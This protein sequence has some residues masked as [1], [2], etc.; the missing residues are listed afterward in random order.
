MTFPALLPHTTLR[1]AF[2]VLVP[3]FQTNHFLDMKWNPLNPGL[4]LTLRKLFPGV[5]P[6]CF[7]CLLSAG[8][9]FIIVCLFNY[10]LAGSVAISRLKKPLYVSS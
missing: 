9:P 5:K 3:T 8:T 4:D 1:A 6:Y 2:F 10:I 7:F